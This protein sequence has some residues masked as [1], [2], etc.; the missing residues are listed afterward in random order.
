MPDAGDETGTTP[1]SGGGHY[2]DETPSIRSAEQE[3]VLTLPD[4]TLTL[5]TDRG[6]F[7]PGHV[8]IGTKY[9]LLD[10]PEAVPGDRHLADVGA[11]YGAIALVLASRNPDATV[12]AIEVNER[13]RALCVRNAEANDLTNVTVVSPEEVPTDIVFDRVWSNPPIRI[14]K[15]ALHELLALWLGRL[16]PNGTAHLVVQKHLGADSLA[17]W[18]T[19]SGWP[20]TRRGSRKAFRL[21]DVTGSEQP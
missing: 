5:T 13:A 8:D 14:G 2:F 3:I 20:T 15:P 6:M 18:I 17:R 7:S 10:G 4:V 1:T 16:S 19:T 11:G 21:L 9:L 12:W